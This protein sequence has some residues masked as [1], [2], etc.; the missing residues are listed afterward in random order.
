ML[1][2]VFCKLTY[3]SQGVGMVHDQNGG[4]W[5]FLLNDIET[6][7]MISVWGYEKSVTWSRRL[8]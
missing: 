6:R 7:D 2:C 3:C 4:I 8:C 1:A 5:I